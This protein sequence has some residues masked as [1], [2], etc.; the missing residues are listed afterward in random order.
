[1]IPSHF[2]PVNI[3]GRGIP[4]YSSSVPV[5]N[6]TNI[7]TANIDLSERTYTLSEALARANWSSQVPEPKKIK[8]YID[9]QIYDP[10]LRTDLTT[11]IALLCYSLF[12]L[13]PAIVL[14]V[15][16]IIFA[17]TK[18]LSQNEEDVETVRVFFDSLG[19]FW[20]PF[21]ITATSSITNIYKLI[22]SY[23]ASK[24]KAAQV[25]S[26]YTTLREGLILKYQQ[27]EG[28][29]ELAEIIH[30]LKKLNLMLP[31]HVSNYQT[32]RKQ[33]K[34]LKQ[35]LGLNFELFKTSGQAL[36]QILLID[37]ISYLKKLLFGQDFKVAADK[38]KEYMKRN[39]SKLENRSALQPQTLRI[40][41]AY[42]DKINSDEE[43]HDIIVNIIS[44]ISSKRERPNPS[45]LTVTVLMTKE[46]TLTEVKDTLAIYWNSPDMKSPLIDPFDAD[47]KHIAMKINTAIR[48]Q[49]PELFLDSG[50][51]SYVRQPVFRQRAA[52][53]AAQLQSFT[54]DISG[55][56]A[57]LTPYGY[58]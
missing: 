44:E 25:L 34:A 28:F 20:A 7:T 23:I 12:F 42:F 47:I 2:Q 19:Y 9:A 49:H 18:R 53:I 17:T 22:K 27:T 37:L 24:E 55:H 3:V 26:S 46:S 16:A 45:E 51:S 8:P 15:R 6:H 1:M 39:A 36:D 21:L 41:P 52:S 32:L 35:K 54:P 40:A 13:A 14:N 11:N 50:I 10:N 31:E 30:N 29:F 5:V 38:I 33:L 57:M 4:I 58:R 48:Y 56:S 43:L